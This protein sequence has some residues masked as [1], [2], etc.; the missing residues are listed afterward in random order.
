MVDS[1]INTILVAYLQTFVWHSPVIAK[2]NCSERLGQVGERRTYDP[3]PCL[4]L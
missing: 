3:F 1:E 4:A 2:Y